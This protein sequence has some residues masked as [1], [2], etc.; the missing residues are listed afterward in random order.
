MTTRQGM[1]P[2]MRELTA[3][4]RLAGAA[5]L[6]W[7][8]F[9][10]AARSALSLG[11]AAGAFSCQRPSEADIQAASAAT[12]FELKALATKRTTQL[13]TAQDMVRD[14]GASAQDLDRALTD[15]SE[16]HKTTRLRQFH[17][18]ELAADLWVATNAGPGTRR[19]ATVLG[20]GLVTATRV[21]P[22]FRPGSELVYSAVTSMG[23]PFELVATDVATGKSYVFHSPMG[24]ETRVWTMQAG[25][26]GRLYLVTSG[27]AHLM[28][29]DPR[30]CQI[31]D[32]G[33]P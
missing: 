23:G 12:E 25:S 30:E 17:Q 29:F 31:E 18:Q 16:T 10:R 11:V 19:L 15:L 4:E 20:K 13:K 6:L 9:H 14:P 22:G 5:R 33:R 7:L 21:G 32:L 24:T 28:R 3:Y 2:P 27:R 26:D 1:K 8:F